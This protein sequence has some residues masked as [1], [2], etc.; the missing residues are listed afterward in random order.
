[1]LHRASGRAERLI[2][3]PLIGILGLVLAAAVVMAFVQPTFLSLSNLTNIGGAMLAIAFLSI[4]MTVVL[5]AGGLDLSVGAVMALSAGVAA[6][7]INNGVPLAGA[8]VAALVVGTGVGAVNG[9]LVTRLE[10]PDF[11]ATLAVGGI[12][13]GFLLYWT[14]GVPI[15]G[16]MTPA[17]EY[18]GGLR[19]LIGPITVPMLVLIVLALVTATL[20]HRTTIGL[21][22]YAVGSS[23]A[24]ARSAG[25]PVNRL[26]VYAYMFSGFVAAVAGIYLAGRTTTVP[27]SMGTG[28]EISAIAAAVIGGASLLGG[29]GRVLGALVGALLLT[30]TRNIINLTGVESSWQTVLTG[31]VLIGALLANHSWGDLVSLLRR[32]LRTAAHTEAYPEPT[33]REG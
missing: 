5:I 3:D 22:L 25:L 6:A 4:A 20:L 10:V 7:V 29:K 23:A 24:A 15:L 13:S 8:F 18:V 27:P 1:M 21:R 11:I 16:Y 26:K 17:Y 28:Y 32:P 12:T 14:R 9:F 2:S 19:R 33:I 30:L 31:A